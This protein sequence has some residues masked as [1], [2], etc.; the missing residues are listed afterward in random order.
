MAACWC[1]CWHFYTRVSK[2]THTLDRCNRVGS[3]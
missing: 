1:S 3:S 2:K